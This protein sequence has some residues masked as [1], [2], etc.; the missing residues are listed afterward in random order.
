MLFGQMRLIRADEVHLS[1]V[2]RK[3][4]AILGFLAL[5]MRP[6]SRQRLCDMF[7]DIPD[8]PR[9]SLRWS[10]TK[11]RPLV[12]AP[13]KARLLSER[14]ALQL[15]KHGLRI[16]ALQVLELAGRDHSTWTAAECERALDIMQGTLLEDCEL[17][18]RPEYMAWL[19]AQRQDFKTI[20]IQLAQWLANGSDGTERRFSDGHWMRRWRNAVLFS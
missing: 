19:Y 1:P 13:E 8:D 15:S 18:D 6:V 9:A 17:P 3:T 4:R 5:S 11:L 10:L 20:A 16:D 12:D 14:D 2:T 7:F